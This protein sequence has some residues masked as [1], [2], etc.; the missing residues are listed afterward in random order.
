MKSLVNNSLFSGHK[1]KCM[2]F[3]TALL[4]SP[5][6]YGCGEA[7]AESSTITIDKDGRISY[8][9]FEDFE[10]DYYDSDE[11]KSMAEREIDEYN[12]G[13]DEA[14][15]TLEDT[16]LIESD[17]NRRVRLT[18]SFSSCED[19][20]NFNREELFYGTVQEAGLKGYDVSESLID[21]DG[22]RIESSYL[23]DNKDKH[24]IIS[25]AA[26][27]V[28]APYNIVYMSKEVSLTGKKEA[29]LSPGFEG[30]IQL[31]LSK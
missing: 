21:N 19:F 2:T 28:V 13:Y 23:N 15:V 7:A 25:G 1:M 14:R 5:V 26:A 20:S 24:V 8:V 11:L 16:K 18:M 10:Q 27:R 6:L 29:A 22:I 9:I 12:A 30:D 3:F 17:D 4:L 31:L